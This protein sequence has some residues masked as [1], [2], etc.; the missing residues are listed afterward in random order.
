MR[1][2]LLAILGL[3]F[4]RMADLA[5]C[6]VGYETQHKVCIDVDECADKICLSDAQCFNTNGG[7]YCQC[8]P[9]Y[10]T[11]SRAV[12]FTTE[13]CRDINECAESREHCGPIISTKCENAIGS[14]FCTCKLG[15]VRSNGTGIFLATDGVTCKD[16][17]ECKA[18][19]TVCGGRA[20]C[21]NTMG[22][23]YCLCDT[24]FRL[25][26][27]KRNFTVPEG[28]C[29]DENECS[30]DRSI[31]GEG[32]H[33]NNTEGSYKCICQPGFSNY[34]VDLAK[35]I[36]LT[37]NHS[38]PDQIPAELEKI[39][40]LMRNGC[41]A[42]SD[43][44]R[45]EG[46]QPSGEMML[47]NLL[48]I[49]DELLAAGPLDSNRQ[50]SVFLDVVE[51]AL[52]LIGALM[53]N[54][55]TREYSE[56]TEVEFLVERGQL[57]PKGEIS[58]SSNH[59][60][61]DTHWETVAGDTTYPGF[62]AASLM[63]FK[64]L[65]SSTNHSFQGLSTDDVGVRFLMNSKV[66]TV[67]V[68]SRNREDLQKPVTFTFSHLQSK[69]ANQC[70]VYWDSASSGGAW[71]RQGC[72]VV[73]SNESYTECNCSHLSSFAVLM[74]LY[75][76]EDTFHLEVITWVGLCLS[77]VCLLL[78]I[79]TFS[80]CRPIQGTRNTIHLHLCICLF[81]ANLIFLAGIS[82]TQ[83]K[84][85]CAFVAGLL[86]FFFLAAFCWMC[87]EGV[88]LYRMV[89]LV[90][91]TTLRPLHM[92][93][94]G[95]GIPAAIVTISAAVYAKGYG[96][97]RHC[98]L[99]LKQGFIWSFFAPVCIIVMVNIFFF[100]I[101]VWKLAEKFSSLNPD[102]TNLRKIKLPRVPSTQE[103]HESDGYAVTHDALQTLNTVFFRHLQSMR[104]AASV[105]ASFGSLGLLRLFGVPW[106]WSLAASLGVY[107]GT[108]GWKFLY[109]VGRT[110]KRDLN[111]LYVL[112]RV[113][114]ALRRHMRKR[115][116]HPFHLC[117]DSGAAPRISLPGVRGPRARPGP[118]PSLDQLSNAVAHWA[119]APGLGPGWAWRAA[120]INFNLRRD[121]LMHCMGASGARGLV[122]GAELA[123]AVLEVS[124]SLHQSMVR[125]CAGELSPDRLASLSAQ[126]LDPLLAAS[127]RLPPPCTH[128]KGFND[129][130]F[131]IYTSGTTGLPK[132][133]IVVHSRYYRIAAFGYHA[134]R[135][136][137][138]D[139][140]YDCLPLYHSAGNIM[141]VGQCL[142]NGLTVVVKKKFSASRFWEDCIKHNCT[143]VQYI[144][145]ICRYLLS[146]P[147]RPA[148]TGH[149]V[150]LAVGNGLRPSVWEAF[151]ERFRV[152][153][154]GEFYGATE[155]NCS[156]AN[157][158]GKVGACGFNSRIM[159]SV[160]PIRLVKVEEE[161]MALVR[162]RK[163]LCVPCQPGEP[164]LL[165]GRI[166]QQD[167]LRRFDGY[168]NQDATSKKISHDVF[169]KGDS[170]YLSG[171]VL[172][173]DD[174]GYMYFRDRSGDTFRWRGENVS[175]TEVEG[176]LSTLLGQADVAVYG[177]PVPGVEGKAGMAA[178]ADR[179][180]QF[181]C[182][183]FLREA[184][185]VLPPYA[186]PVFL[187]ISPQVDTTGTFKIQ[188][189]RL[190]REGYDP[191]LTN[192][193]IY[194]LNSRAGRYEAVNEKLYSAIVEGRV[195]L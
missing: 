56:Q 195:S 105:S 2:V 97:D 74:A 89:V 126:P 26:S 44:R 61:L 185:Q 33:C 184:Q 69:Q 154:V 68:S 108:G 132:A 160:Y 30:A 90:F 141:G 164:G 162:D 155:C 116:H 188:K 136:R 47:K 152:A 60:H 37:C 36:E 65:E 191:R 104:G 187:R 46:G 41:L 95:Y 25:E 153:Q 66:V 21:F 138:D 147:V 181:D 20:K 158:D 35:C 114:L 75:E 170:A 73:R 72:S 149:R 34:G 144:G 71:S 43:S 24:G 148:E 53:H 62:A 140:I 76:I 38:T 32:G 40:S 159:P 167:P 94:A 107:L 16:T 83:N 156:I 1:R 31:C 133:A 111:G 91:N 130:L 39:F 145:E 102:L 54:G 142:I 13:S 81:I 106:S 137:H 27:G 192:D 42:L 100:L 176:T 63:T 99:D 127:P 161:T 6:P 123:D 52:Q 58:L 84:V 131:Y 22:S 4:S 9:G 166:N 5:Q 19:S 98:W 86:H 67:S 45:R 134:F 49:I 57:S 173:M 59:A 112:L 64:G 179:A 186:R 7:Y 115:Q 178:I 169:K 165:V 18:N 85:G 122:F 10:R 93:A 183:A 143:V 11:R 150:R 190:Q 55:S 51:H 29:E 125:L 88:Q 3:S 110:A 113:K 120:L 87:L 175:T 135:M 96:T 139:I 163:G 124:A 23:Y 171:D 172:V 79:I 28:T 146:Q 101:T 12:N 128:R 48:S 117:P 15:F 168:A 70:C 118:S 80:C 151:T 14:Y 82:S 119:L 193:R 17:D 121:S 92:A 180:G 103:S 157:M 8:D 174:L 177:V 77:Q 194:F 109:V 129:R 78:C 182:A 189:T 50:V